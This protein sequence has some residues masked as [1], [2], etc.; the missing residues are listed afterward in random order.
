MSDDARRELLTGKTSSL[1]RRGRTRDIDGRIPTRRADPYVWD[2]SH[3][4]GS[5]ESRRVI[6]FRLLPV[7]VVP[8]PPLTS[9][10]MLGLPYVEQDAEGQ[11]TAP[12][13]PAM[14]DPDIAE[15]GLRAHRRLQN[16]LAALVRE[17][18]LQPRR[19]GPRDPDFDLAWDNRATS[20]SWR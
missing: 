18:G 8:P 1:S 20:P 14:I 5:T 2:A 3:D 17:H 19:P 7:D 15:R 11:V 9:K 12:I 10:P 13:T 6:R 16:H 4:S